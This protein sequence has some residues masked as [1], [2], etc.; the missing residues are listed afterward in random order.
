MDRALYWLVTAVVVVTAVFS[1]L[2]VL[3]TA[4]LTIGIVS[5]NTAAFSLGVILT[6]FPAIIAYLT[7]RRWGW[8]PKRWSL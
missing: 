5:S 7:N 4:F 3:A 1:W 2:F 8:W 6:S